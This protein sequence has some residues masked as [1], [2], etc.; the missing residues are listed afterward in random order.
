MPSLTVLACYAI[1]NNNIGILLWDSPVI[2]II[3]C[4]RKGNGNPYLPYL[5][6]NLTLSMSPTL[7]SPKN[8]NSAHYHSLLFINRALV[9][10]SANANATLPIVLLPCQLLLAYAT[11]VS[12]DGGLNP[13]TV[14]SS[15]PVGSCKPQPSLIMYVAMVYAVIY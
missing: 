14:L 4:I 9:T 5:S 3:V 11:S 10:I 2:S 7:T 6:V 8:I 13:S 15:L 1:C 12:A